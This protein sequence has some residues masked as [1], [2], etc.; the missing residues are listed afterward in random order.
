MVGVN[1]AVQ[2]QDVGQDAPHL[3]RRRLGRLVTRVAGAPLA[4]AARLGLDLRVPHRRVL[5]LRGLHALVLLRGGLVERGRLELVVVRVLDDEVR[6]LAVRGRGRGR[7]VVLVRLVLRDD[8]LD[9]DA[10]ELGLALGLD[11]LDLLVVREM[12]EVLGVIVR[13]VRLCLGR[14]V[15]LL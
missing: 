5:R 6:V 8:L 4:L 14:G 7:G 12:F 3:V 1:G 11:A 2:G 10:L 15:E 13:L 9:G